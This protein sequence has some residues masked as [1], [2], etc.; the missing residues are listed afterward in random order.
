M[1]A[2]LIC[3]LALL[4]TAR[5]AT[6]ADE[7][8]R[9]TPEELEQDELIQVLTPAAPELTEEMVRSQMPDLPAG[10]TIE[11]VEGPPRSQ[12][13]TLEVADLN[14]DEGTRFSDGTI[15]SNVG[16]GGEDLTIEQAELTVNAI[17][18][19]T[20]VDAIPLDDLPSKN[21]TVAS[22]TIV[23]LYDIGSYVATTT[24]GSGATQ[25]TS[26]AA[27]TRLT[28]PHT[29]ETYAEG[30]IPPF[31]SATRAG[32]SEI[33]V[34]FQRFP[35]S[36]PDGTTMTVRPHWQYAGFMRASSGGG[37]ANGL[38]TAVSRYEKDAFVR[39]DNGARVT[40][41]YVRLGLAPGLVGGERRLFPSNSNTD[42]ADL[43][44]ATFSNV[45]Y[46]IYMRNASTA[47]LDT[48]GLQLG[49]ASAE[50]DFHPTVGPASRSF[51]G[52]W[53]YTNVGIVFTPPPGVVLRC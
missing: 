7:V 41:R 28:G 12:E 25:F 8:D 52:A 32:F 26:A 47:Q 22:N 14:A 29:M 31:S 44:I 24:G 17:E 46:D 20:V 43:S 5:P 53:F 48:R 1:P 50:A 4:A 21:L 37:G 18:P 42:A 45:T 36:W 13:S 33:G 38:P 34:R 6:A 15:V 9:L 16:P 2:V 23:C 39:G 40:E 35:S 3:T 51:G 19:P 49:T 27:N 11:K 30:T 10:A